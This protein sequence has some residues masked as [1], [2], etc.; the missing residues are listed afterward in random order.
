MHCRSV[1]AGLAVVFALGACGTGSVITRTDYDI[2]YDPAL[3]GHAIQGG[4]MPLAVYGQPFGVAS[5]EAVAAALR[6]PGYLPQAP[7][8]LDP[9]AA[10]GLGT[11][12]VLLFDPAVTADGRVACQAPQGGAGQGSAGGL[13]VRA[14]LCVGDTAASTTFLTLPHA[15]GPDDPVF[16]GGL[17]QMMAVLTGQPRE[18]NREKNTTVLITTPAITNLP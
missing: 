5:G 8:Q 3:V 11:R 10:A 9:K 12:I 17:D 2:L 4:H 16:R 15:S 13:S 1:A 6:L 18:K 14:A 7:V